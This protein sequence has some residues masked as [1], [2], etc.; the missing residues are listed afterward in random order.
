[1]TIAH[2]GGAFH[3]LFDA[4]LGGR[5][6]ITPMATLTELLESCSNAFRAAARPTTAIATA[7]AACVAGGAAAQSVTVS[8][9]PFGGATHIVIPTAQSWAWTPPAQFPPGHAPH[10][11]GGIVPL[12]RPRPVPPAPPTVVIDAVNVQVAVRDAAAT[13][14]MDI[15]LRNVG[16][17]HAEA[18]LV[19]P[20]PYEAVVS[21][22]QAEGVGSSEGMARLLPRDEARRIYDSIVA[23]V[24]DPALLEFAGWN[25]VRSSVFPIEPGGTQRVRL[26]FDH[27]LEAD[28]DRLDL[29]LPRS[30]TMKA[31]VPWT[32]SVD[33]EGQRPIVD[34]YSPTHEIRVRRDRPDR[35]T[36]D[37]G[38][39][40]RAVSG[41][42]RLSILREAVAGSADM[43][44]FAASV[45][46]TPDPSI[47]GGYFLLL[48]T[49]PPSRD[50]AVAGPR[51]ITLVL[52]R[53]GSMA[54]EKLRQAR[55]SALWLVDK[56][57]PA[58][59][60]NIIDYSTTVSGLFDSPQPLTPQNREAAQRYLQQLPASGGTNIHDALV[61]A[62][63]QQPAAGVATRTIVFLTDGLPTV[64]R[65]VE[66]EIRAAVEK[67]NKHARR[68]H[69]LGVGTDVNA[70]LLD[71]IG[72]LTRGSTQYVTPGGAIAEPV[73]RLS[74]KLDGPAL[75]DLALAESAGAGAK[76]LSDV[77]PAQLPDLHAGEQLVILGRYR[78]GDGPLNLRVAGVRSGRPAT[79]T[80]V[81][82]PAKSSTRNAFVGRLWASRQINILADEVRQLTAPG[83]SVR[84]DDPRLRELTEQILALSA[85][86]GVLTEYTSFLATDGG[87][88]V[89]HRELVEQC[90]DN[91]WQMA[92]QTRSGAAAVAQGINYNDRK[93]QQTL[94]LDNRFKDAQLNDTNFV[95]VCQVAD[96]GFFRRGDRWIDGRL[97]SRADA[98]E[99]ARTV[100]VGTPEYQALVD[101]LVRE[102]RQAIISLQGDIVVDVDGEAVLVT[103]GC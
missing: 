96:R 46:T 45:M 80:I 84:P 56:L 82:D 32:I 53:S 85:R 71:R 22:F 26:V 68:I 92:G 62:L 102:N 8:V 24:R 57:R 7:F 13:T 59:S 49:L 83:A 72:D 70:P 60:L 89:A 64:G 69:A 61:E 77:L 37:L 52:D 9:D 28:G 47:G 95:Q 1:M 58:D 48:A 27:I 23:Q 10:P 19:L 88:I 103:G 101:K 76:H 41:P 39:S 2:P 33:I 21:S 25:L 6:E 16:G 11:P 17:S 66:A 65:T 79:A 5:S 51:E 87:S 29:V 74:R 30:E 18:V 86:W 94:N 34:T 55:E 93:V 99:P 3:L 38:A 35:L 97:L 90:G 50:E 14:T 12:P 15:G 73:Q 44:G 36:V 81:L 98:I 4:A 75:T 100:F 63:M 78:D 54:G 91:L 31:T 67:G 40:P 20:L 42:F 43:A